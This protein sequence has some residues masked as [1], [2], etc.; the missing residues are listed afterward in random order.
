MP[1]KPRIHVPGGVYHVILRGNDRQRIFF[2]DSDRT[3]WED[4]VARGIERYDCRIHAYC[5]M[6][7]HIHIAV[8]VDD[9]PLWN[10]MRWVASQYAR[11]L[12]GRQRRTG[13]L[14]ERRHRAILVDAERYLLGLVRYIHLN[15]VNAGIVD[16]AEKYLW[17]SHAAYLGEARVD[18]LTTS[19][20]LSYFST[21]NDDGDSETRFHAFVA[22]ADGPVEATRLVEGS[23][24]DARVLGNDS[25]CAQVLG[26]RPEVRSATIDEVVQSYCERHGVIEEELISPG[27]G[28]RN[29]AIRAEIAWEVMRRKI[30][31]LAEV[32]RRFGRAE[33]VLSRGV[34]RRA[35]KVGGD[36]Q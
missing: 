30:A 11:S 36:G 5:W 8:Q 33:S 3:E 25:F 35:A 26:H 10:L 23:R 34:S 13:H 18:W 2:S 32:A 31:S 15:P 1:R 14:F 27:R 20:V 6:S 28:R 19:L 12:N 7:N 29:A 22:D 4:L 16:R 21:D 17:S 9:I 24:T